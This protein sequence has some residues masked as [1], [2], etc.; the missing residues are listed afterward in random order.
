VTHQVTTYTALALH[1]HHHGMRVSI[2]E[3]FDGPPLR[4]VSAPARDT[5]VN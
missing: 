3:D 4:I 1:F 5:A 2:R